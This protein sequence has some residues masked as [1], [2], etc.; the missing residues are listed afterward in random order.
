MTPFRDDPGSNGS[1]GGSS[2]NQNND[3]KSLGRSLFDGSCSLFDKPFDL[4]DPLEHMNSLWQD[5]P[6][7]SLFQDV[8][9]IAGTKVDWKE[10]SDAHVFKADLPGKMAEQHYLT[11]SQHQAR[12]LLA[13]CARSGHVLI[14]LTTR[15]KIRRRRHPVVYVLCSWCH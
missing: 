3:C 9:A 7:R 11:Q 2:R 1:G 12:G 6:M 5:G 14:A 13:S 4:W 8:R 10:T 15:L